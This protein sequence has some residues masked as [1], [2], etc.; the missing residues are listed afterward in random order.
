LR[1]VV[2]LEVDNT[3]DHNVVVDQVGRK[4]I[5]T[6]P[7]TPEDD[8]HRG[9]VHGH[10]TLIRS[11]FDLLVH[12]GF[13]LNVA[14]DRELQILSLL[15]Q[16]DFL[17]ERNITLTPCLIVVLQFCDFCRCQ[18]RVLLNELQDVRADNV[19]LLKFNATH[20]IDVGAAPIL[21]LNVVHCQ[22]LTHDILHVNDHVLSRLAV[23][24]GFLQ[25]IIMRFLPQGDET[26]QVPLI[27]WIRKWV[28]G[29]ILSVEGSHTCFGRVDSVLTHLVF[30]IVDGSL[31]L[32]KTS[33]FFSQAFLFFDTTLLLE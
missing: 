30:T 25:C 5:V 20:F 17:T 7:Q 32:S 27:R 21:P 11:E 19:K 2:H 29:Q 14:P 10:G 16:K 12:H 8:H 22:R 18:L 4:V 31:L 15:E 33:S 1:V 13:A 3:T 24:N 9:F 28:A 6:G 26:G 23:I